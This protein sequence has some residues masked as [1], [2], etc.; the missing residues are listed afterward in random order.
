MENQLCVLTIL[1]TKHHVCTYKAT[2][3]CHHK[4]HPVL[5]LRASSECRIKCLKTDTSQ[6]EKD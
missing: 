3:I 4:N 1:F 5:P 6:M 2:A